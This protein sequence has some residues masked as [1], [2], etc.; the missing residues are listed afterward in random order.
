M[1]MSIDG[2]VSIAVFPLAKEDDGR[3]LLAVSVW[4]PETVVLVRKK[5]DWG[6]DGKVNAKYKIALA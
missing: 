5:L 1:K 3:L 2:P 4:Q 6:I